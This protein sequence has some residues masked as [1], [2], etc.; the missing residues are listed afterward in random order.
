MESA[1][2]GDQQDLRVNRD[3]C[4]FIVKTKLHLLYFLIVQRARWEWEK[5]GLSAE[6][7]EAS[8][9]L[10]KLIGTTVLCQWKG[11]KFLLPEIVRMTPL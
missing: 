6:V 2:E 5:G 10:D 9:D 3:G 8:T 11:Y 4:C 1:E 7:E